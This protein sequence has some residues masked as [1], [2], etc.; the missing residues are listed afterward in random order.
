MRIYK[1]KGMGYHIESLGNTDSMI[2]MVTVLI[3]LWIHLHF[4][5]L[6]T[7]SLSLHPNNH[8]TIQNCSQVDVGDHLTLLV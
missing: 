1:I 6:I 7:F 5:F 4:S 3:S 8:V 2:T